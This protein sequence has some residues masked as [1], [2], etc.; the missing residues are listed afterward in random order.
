VYYRT[1][2]RWRDEWGRR[3]NWAE[4]VDR[5]TDFLFDKAGAALT[6]E[7]RYNITAAIHDH[8]ALPSMRLLWSAGEAAKV[9]EIATYN[10]AYAAIDDLRAFDE[11]LFILMNGTGF[12]FSVE[13]EYVEQLPRILK[14]KRNQQKVPYEISDSREGWAQAL[15]FGLET[16]F[17]GGDVEFDYSALRPQGARLK[18][19]GG[20]SSGPDPLRRLLEFTRSKVQSRAGRR[21][22]PINC[23]DILCTIGEVVVA[24]GVRRSSL[25]SLSDLDNYDMRMAKYG[26][27]YNTAP[28]RSMANNSVAYNEKPDAVEFMEEF[29]NLAKSGSGE[30]G[31]FNR[32]SVLSTAPRRKK[33]TDWGLNP[34]MPAG[35]LVGTSLGIIPIERLEGKSFQVKSLSGEWADATCWKS[36]V[37]VPVC[38][39]DFG[40]NRLTMSTPD[41]KWPVLT[42]RGIIRK[43]T[44]DLSPGDKV[45]L[46]RNELTGIEVDASLTRDDGFFCG[47]LFGDGWISQR[48]SGTREGNYVL[49][50]SI[51][52]GKESLADRLV[53]YMNKNKSY[54]STTRQSE[55]ESTIQC[56][57][58]G[59]IRTLIERFGWHL[60]KAH[61]PDKVWASND[62]FVLGFLDGLFSSDGHVGTGADLRVSLTTSKP[63]VAVELQKL[64]SFYGIPS[65]VSV[66]QIAGT[67]PNGKDYDRTYTS[68]LVRVP[69]SGTQNF[70]NIVT[71]SNPNKSA[72]LA[73]IRPRPVIEYGTVKSVTQAGSADVWDIS[74][75]HEQHVF[76]AQ[77]TYTGNC[78]EILLRS[79][80]FCN[81]TSVVA[82]EEDTLDSL[83]DKVRIATILGTVQS[84]FTNFPYI[85]SD[86]KKNC[87]EER[88]LGVSINGQ[89]DCPV[90]RD[91]A[92]L[93]TLRET[94]I[95]VNREY[96]QRLGINPSAAITTGKP[97]GTESQIVTSGSGA[98]TWWDR[99]YIR[100]IRISV[101]DPLF[102]LAKNY[103]VPCEPE[104]G[105]DPST[106][107]TWVL[108]FPVKA[109]ASAIT[110]HER[111]AIQ[112][113]E[114][115][116]MMKTRW[117]EH[118]QSVTIYVKNHEYP[119]VQGW[120]YD[121]WDLVSGLSFLPSEDHV[122]R[123]APYE[124]VTEAKYNE[125]VA[126]FPQEIDYS[127]LSTLELEDQTTG[128]RDFAC[129][130]GACEL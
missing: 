37:D 10:C 92:V 119:A 46:N 82:R 76:P 108:S 59:F 60:K 115:W 39:V 57:D 74:V 66:N 86:W 87:D 122:Y 101:T 73:D 93:V 128:A 100:R 30:R 61:I 123:L 107:S 81:L 12:G 89:M 56:S 117:C 75:N 130:S 42:D 3:E 69:R 84:T 114:H 55:D 67:F 6:D 7:D 34:S 28:Y 54:K 109:P 58:Q 64:L 18:T 121:H 35:T 41:H 110:R 80:Q 83:S 129:T 8:E 45:P 127:L 105:Q 104:V 79:K 112:Q 15:R 51:G 103:G 65:A 27:F 78:S 125:L 20:R 24:G 120:V 21:L 23:H 50:I 72:R 113:L 126:A 36:G 43:R 25:I 99:Y 14:P 29:L 32:E 77:H 26:A 5:A 85:R 2:S 31:I 88:L 17:Q 13:S 4:T 19:M 91:P 48:T 102:Q 90:V 1:Y 40:M 124:S 98:H 95:S 94:A 47:F 44:A 111:D 53:A 96:A 9:S 70:K 118:S 33:H 11:A 97:A 62:E 116:L 52:S 63:D 106:A 68:C 38:L 16:W 22:S 71:L 49:G